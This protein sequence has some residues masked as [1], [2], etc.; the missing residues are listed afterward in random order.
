[1]DD[2]ANIHIEEYKNIGIT[3]LSERVFHMISSF[4]LE[5]GKPMVLVSLI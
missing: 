5:R 3:L 2:A 4:A 1:M